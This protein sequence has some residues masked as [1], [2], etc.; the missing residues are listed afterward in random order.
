MG[1]DGVE[2]SELINV[3][4]RSSLTQLKHLLVLEVNLKVIYFE[5]FRIY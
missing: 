3:R 4:Q 2:M 5:T 1:F